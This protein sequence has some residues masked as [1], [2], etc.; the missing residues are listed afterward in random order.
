MHGFE[1][2]Y[3]CQKV[4]F[5]QKEQ[6]DVVFIKFQTFHAGKVCFIVPLFGNAPMCASIVL[7]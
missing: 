4:S 3:Y 7:E 2:I 5:F 1:L 6:S